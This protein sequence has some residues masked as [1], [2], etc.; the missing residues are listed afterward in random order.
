MFHQF[1]VQG[2]HLS[3]SQCFYTFRWI[4]FNIIIF[5]DQKM[6]EIL[7]VLSLNMNTNQIITFTSEVV[8]VMRILF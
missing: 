7:I 6:I 4:Y 1:V 8:T 5:T 2:L 3:R